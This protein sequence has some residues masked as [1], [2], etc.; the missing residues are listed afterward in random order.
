MTNNGSNTYSYGNYYNWYSATAGRA[1]SNAS[2]AEG[3][4]CPFG[5][6]MPT[7]YKSGTDNGGFGYLDRQM[8]GSGGDYSKNS[9][10]QLYMGVY[11]R[12]FPNNF[13]YTY[14][15]NSGEYWS[16]LP[17]TGTNAINTYTLSYD[18]IKIGGT[19]SSRQWYNGLPIRCLSKSNL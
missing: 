12:S 18:Y 1:V 5:W 16:S 14:R 19:A 15:G 17:W 7:A 6:G 10:T 9:I 11:W 2:T 4:L 13:I 3:D 8:G